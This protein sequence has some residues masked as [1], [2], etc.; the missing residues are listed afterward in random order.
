MPHSDGSGGWGLQLV[1]RVAST[2]G[3]KVDEP[4]CVWFELA[5]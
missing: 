2:W 1:D 4:T 3:V 5:R